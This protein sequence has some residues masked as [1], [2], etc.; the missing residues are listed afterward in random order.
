MH[1]SGLELALVFLLA[2]V[3]AV[4]VFKRFGLGAVLAYLVAGVVLGPDGLALVRDA[5]RILNAAEIG[6]V[7]MLFVIGLEL[8]PSRLRV[9]RKPVFGAGGLQVLLSALLLG[10]AFLGTF[11][12]RRASLIGALAGAAIF[13]CAWAWGAARLAEPMPARGMPAMVRLVQP[14]APQALKWQ[15]GYARMFFDRHLALSALP[16][17]EGAREITPPISNAPIL[18]EGARPVP[19][20]SPETAEPVWLDQAGAGLGI[21]ITLAILRKFWAA[22]A[23]WNSSFAPFGPRRRKRSSFRMRFR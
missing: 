20:I 1:G 17:G 6:V 21:G 9:M 15:E 2:A 3:I 18:A 7:M 14:N 4:P 22:A 23:R 8:S 19:V 11:T 12:A 5:D 10:L 13:A 16:L